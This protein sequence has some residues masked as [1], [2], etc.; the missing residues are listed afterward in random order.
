MLGHYERQYPE[1]PSAPIAKVDNINDPL[2]LEILKRESPDFVIVSGTNLVGKR[3]IDEFP[4]RILNLHTGISP[5]VKGGPNCTNWCL[6]RNWFHLIGNTV[7]WIDPGIDTGRILATEQTPLTGRESLEELHLK[8]M[9]HAHVL[10]LRVLSRFAENGPVDGIP[11]NS[12]ADGSV[13]FSVDWNGFEARRA[14]RNFEN[15]FSRYF[16]D[17]NRLKDDSGHLKL[18]S[19][20]I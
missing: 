6:A 17:S 8:V 18:V 1:Y 9:D 4:N 7:M 19:A 13:F 12:I 20:D 2:T 16:R 15:N 14:L 10:Y 3:L 5:Y 11:Q